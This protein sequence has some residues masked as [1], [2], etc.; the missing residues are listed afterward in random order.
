MKKNPKSY[1]EALKKLSKRSKKLTAY[2]FSGMIKVNFVGG[3][4]FKIHYVII[5]EDDYFLYIWTEH[6]GDFAWCKED[7]DNWK[8]TASKK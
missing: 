2:D 6:F 5:E 4:V 7:I 8:Y 1:K 3:D